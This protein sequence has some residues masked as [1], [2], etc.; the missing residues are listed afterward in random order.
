M[1]KDHTADIILFIEHH[2][3]DPTKTYATINNSNEI[4]EAL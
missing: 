1:S 4:L 2:K 3:S